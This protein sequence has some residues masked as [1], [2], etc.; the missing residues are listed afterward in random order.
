MEGYVFSRF[1]FHSSRYCYFTFGLSIACRYPQLRHSNVGGIISPFVRSTVPRGL[2]R[3]TVQSINRARDQTGGAND[4]RCDVPS[5]AM[6]LS[7]VRA[8]ATRHSYIG[9]FDAFVRAWTLRRLDGV[10]NF[11]LISC[12]FALLVLS[13][14]MQTNTVLGTVGL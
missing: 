7:N 9:G 5:L 4:S 8:S 11:L 1:L 12:V 3:V 14:L 13:C 10:G 6:R 2:L